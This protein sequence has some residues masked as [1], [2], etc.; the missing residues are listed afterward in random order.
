MTVRRMGILLAL[1]AA[2]LVSAAPAPAPQPVQPGEE[3]LITE[4]EIGRHGGRLTASL[5]SEPK[6]LNPVL[7]VDAPSLEIIAR[8]TADLIHINRHTQKTEPALAKSWTVSPD[9][10]RY[11]LHLRRGLRFSDGH[12]FDADDVLFTFQVLLD[13]EVHSPQRD[14][15]VIDGEPLRVRKLD[16]HTVVFELARPYAAAERLFDSI[17]I[18]PRHR[19]EKTYQEG[20]LARA[21]GLTT[22]PEEIAGLGPFRLKQHVPGQRLVLERNP[23]YW[24]AD[25]RK[26]RLPYLDEISFLIVP[27]EDAQVIR[28]QAGDLDVINQLSAENFAVLAPEQAARHF[29]LYDLGPSLEYNFVFFNLNDLS[30]APV[31]KI[32][33]KQ[34]WFRQ[35]GFRQAVSAAIDREAIV[36][37]IYQGRAVPLRTHVT[38]GN[39]MWFN[40]ALRAPPASAAR[41]RELLKAS[42]F[43]WR[44]DGGLVDSRGELVEFSIVTNAGNTQ[45]LKMA[46]IIQDDLTKLGM[47]V[48]VV[49][50]EFQALVE[51]VF[52]TFDYEACLLGLV[53]G[54]ADPNPEMNV[55][56][57][58]GAT[59]L[60]NLSQS[61]PAAPWEA[62]IDRLMRQQM[63]TV[64]YKERKRLYDRVQELVAENL[65]L[66]CLV[67]RNI[68]VGAKN[69]V[70]GFRP[71]VVNDYT[72]W[73]ADELFLRAQERSRR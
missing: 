34:A 1:F 25:R 64:D 43:S 47:R 4:N 20:K 29:R 12:P 66:I 59:R 63:T 18:L 69:R 58:D 41:A 8:L 28:F 68:L 44:E 38:P 19:L 70:G 60:W 67:S 26:N 21:W 53:S 51:R 13:E 17:A 48:H 55:W 49:P 56:V 61:R 50:L 30:A 31:E 33:R 52:R 42:G 62:E 35:T 2:A 22:P 46:T 73:N 36:R 57:S 71:G 7:A 10:R 6:T 27:T 11:T 3:L 9:G 45:R 65:P 16:S 15:L 24:K 5:R 72:L 40:A 54:D 32:R 39:R 23:Y 37:L 14:F